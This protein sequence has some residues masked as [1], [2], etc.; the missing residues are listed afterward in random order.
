MATVS[1]KLRGS[2]SRF[3]C[4]YSNEGSY[5]NGKDFF[6][7]GAL[8]KFI[9]VKSSFHN[10]VPVF[11]FETIVLYL[12]NEGN[13][14]ILPLTYSNEKARKTYKTAH[15]LFHHLINTP[16]VGQRL[17]R[18]R[19][20]SGEVF[21]GANGILLDSNRNPIMLATIR[22]EGLSNITMEEL[23]LYIN[24]KV[25]NNDGILNKYI[26]DKIIPHI[27]SGIYLTGGPYIRGV[28][29]R[30]NMD[31]YGIRREVTPKIV[32]SDTINNF[33]TTVV[34]DG[35]DDASEI[36]LHN[37]EDFFRCLNS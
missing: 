28:I 31:S 2:T 29:N 26:K 20:S 7:N 3:F 19:A 35:R 13:E 12:K 36:I 22:T 16:A 30:L 10:E 14:V 37:L 23:I 6:H 32:I 17:T 34:D 1:E 25:F 8:D 24:P 21:Y 27:L 9:Y 18:I 5:Y 33:F 4:T 11:C 15:M